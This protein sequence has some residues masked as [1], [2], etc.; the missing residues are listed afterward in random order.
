VAT[1]PSPL[2]VPPPAPQAPPRRKKSAPAAFHLQVLQSCD[3][4]FLAVLPCGGRGDRPPAPPPDGGALLPQAAGLGAP[5]AASP[6]SP[7]AEQPQ[8][9]A[10][11]PLGDSQDPF[12][13]LLHHPSLL[14][15]A[16]LSKSCDPLDSGTRGLE[17]AHTAPLQGSASA[18]RELPPGRGPRDS[19]RCGTGSDRDKRTVLQVFDPLA[20]T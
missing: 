7:G 8:S 11:S 20:K 14:K 15:N 19:D 5:S 1:P 4:P 6:A 13:S 17:R 16:W 10:A 12:W 18:A 3:S 2:E 9:E